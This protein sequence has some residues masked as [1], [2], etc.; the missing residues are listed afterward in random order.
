MDKLTVP[1][2]ILCTKSHEY[3]LVD[4]SEAKIGIT[5]YAVDQLGDVVFVE[6]PE[7]GVSCNKGESFG[8]IESVKAASEIYMPLSG[9]VSEINETL[10]TQPELVNEDCYEKG[11]LI[12]VTGFDKND[13]DDAMSYD[14]YKEYL[15][16]KEEEEE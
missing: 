4:G 12:K 14:E 2:N 3:V 8:T 9:K 1:N 10:A 6:L 16:S 5:D 11:W 15:E 7:I 13:L